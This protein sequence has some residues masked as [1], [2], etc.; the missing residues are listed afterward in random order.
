[1]HLIIVEYK[2]RHEKYYCW[3]WLNKLKNELEFKL[4]QQYINRIKFHLSKWWINSEWRYVN[5]IIC[6]P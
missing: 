5:E 3:P 1:M 4:K 2:D 6:K